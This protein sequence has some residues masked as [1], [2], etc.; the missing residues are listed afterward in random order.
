MHKARL[1]TPQLERRRRNR[2]K[3]LPPLRKLLP[4]LLLLVVLLG[5]PVLLFGF[6]TLRRYADLK[7]RLTR[8]SQKT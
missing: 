3:L 7:I 1:R 4:L 8:A 5:V 2:R 6:F